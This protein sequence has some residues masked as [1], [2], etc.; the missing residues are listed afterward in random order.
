MASFVT[1]TLKMVACG[2]T[3]GKETVTTQPSAVYRNV[4]EPT[5]PS[6]VVFSS[7]Q[8]NHRAGARSLYFSAM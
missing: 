7:A 1:T 5:R 4:E 8:V 2:A 6:G 3:M